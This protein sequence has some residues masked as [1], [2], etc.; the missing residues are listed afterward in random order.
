VAALPDLLAQERVVDAVS[1]SGIQM[2]PK[3]SLVIIATRRSGSN[4]LCQTIERLGRLGRPREHFL[5]LCEEFFAVQHPERTLSNACTPSE[6]LA[7]VHA[8]GTTPNGISSAKIMGVYLDAV[9]GKLR[10]I[11]QMPG[12]P[13]RQVLSAV[14]PNA[15]YIYLVRRDKAAQAVSLAKALMSGSWR[16]DMEQ[17]DVSEEEYDFKFIRDLYS[18]FLAAEIRAEELFRELGVPPL[19]L[20]YEDMA[21]QLDQIVT[22]ICSSMGVR[23]PSGLRLGV[24]W[25]N[26]QADVV[27]EGWTRRFEAD[28]S[29]MNVCSQAH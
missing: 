5:G 16:S 19:R 9:L 28:L 17:R 15:R 27:N 4:L 2:K 3:R 7:T 6:Y 13:D 14:F 20:Y 18:Q 23:R 25:L 8:S 21:A 10:E 11:L 1:S 24:P 22:R 12:A 26:R 29:A